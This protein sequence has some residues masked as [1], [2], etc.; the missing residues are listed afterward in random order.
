MGALA[1]IDIQ[2]R[3]GHIR[4]RHE[5]QHWP[6]SIGRALELADVGGLDLYRS[7]IELLT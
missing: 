4:Q 7:L 5:V 6:G 2:E 1:I 3:D